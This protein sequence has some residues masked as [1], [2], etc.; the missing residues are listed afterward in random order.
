LSKRKSKRQR[1][2]DSY[3][4]AIEEIIAKYVAATG[5][6]LWTK[7][8]VA[9][10]AIR[11]GLHDAPVTSPIKKLADTIGRY[12]RQVSIV[13]EK[14]RTV[15]KY[16]AFQYEDGQPTLWV[17]KDEIVPEQMDKS[18]TLRRNKLASG[19]IQLQTTWI[20]LMRTATQV[21]RLRSILTFLRI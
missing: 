21:T 5:D 19:A 11:N 14:G 1:S 4:K 9:E 10:W 16:L 12:A 18:K 6:H 15:R 7:Y 17:D 8:K 20:I 13:D 2:A 3:T